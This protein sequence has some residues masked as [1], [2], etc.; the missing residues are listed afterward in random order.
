MYAGLGLLFFFLVLFLQQIAGYSAI[1]AGPGDPADHAADVLLSR[2]FGALADRFGPR[3]FMGVGP[4]VA[5]AGCS[6]FL[7][8]DAD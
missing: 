8:V 5:G 4:L 3:F 7:R 6:C 2:R 1:E